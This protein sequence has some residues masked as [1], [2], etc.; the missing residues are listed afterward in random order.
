[1]SSINRFMM[2][3][4]D[5]CPFKPNQPRFVDALITGGASLVGNLLGFG[6]NQSA[7]QINLEIAKQNAELQRE[8]NAQNYKI[9]QEQNA[10]NEQMW[11][12]QNEYNLPSNVVKRLL[13]AGIN[14]SAVFGNG[15]Y[16]EAGSLQSV[17]ASPMVAPQLN[18]RVSPYNPDLSGVGD[19]ANA[20]FQNQLISKNIESQGIDN[21]AKQIDL[22][23]K[24]QRIILDMREQ[25][26]RIDNNLAQKGL[27]EQERQNLISQKKD[28]DNRI[29]LFEENYEYLSNREKLQNDVLENQAVNLLADSTL[30]R[31]QA[32]FQSMMMH[33]YP[34]ITQADLNVKTAEFN[35]LV[36]SAQLKVKEGKLTSAK[37]TQQYLQNGL[38]AIE[39][40]KERLKDK[41]RNSNRATKTFYGT[42]DMIGSTIFSNLKS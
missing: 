36:Q 25:I 21:Q 30:K 6:S 10:F 22:Q 19:A 20:F 37:A 39:Y 4:I 41:A 9:F 38:D 5:S 17:N 24:V 8:T 26:S 35:D 15:S 1:M 7:N 11:N 13:D 12:K 3:T 32:S 28:M 33:Y 23:Y 29:K 34:Q 40:R 42:L 2:G 16:S 27:S 18:A 14:P 31:V